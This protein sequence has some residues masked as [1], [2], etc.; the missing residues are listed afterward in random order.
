MISFD[1][2][3]RIASLCVVSSWNIAL[4]LFSPRLLA[5]FEFSAGT[6]NKACLYIS[7]Q[8]VQKP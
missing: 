1:N 2:F 3:T 5:K 6:S 7:S 4:L 8:L